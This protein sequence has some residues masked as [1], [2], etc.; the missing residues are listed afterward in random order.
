MRPARRKERGRE[1]RVFIRVDSFGLTCAKKG[2]K[3][4]YRDFMG[5]WSWKEK[6]DGGKG[7]LEG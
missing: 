5:L 2:G 6:E 1:K 7:F 4:K 3:K